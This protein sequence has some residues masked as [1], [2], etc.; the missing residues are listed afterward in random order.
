MIKANKGDLITVQVDQVKEQYRETGDY[1]KISIESNETTGGFEG[2]EQLSKAHIYRIEK[3]DLH[4]DLEKYGVRVG[5]FTLRAIKVESFSFVNEGEVRVNGEFDVPFKVSRRTKLADS[6]YFDEGVARAIATGLNMTEMEKLEE[7]ESS[8]EK[9]KNM[10][11]QILES[12][13]V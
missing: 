11:N 9:A 5:H 10:L 8:V 1:S 2:L 4:K 7:L 3:D 13:H 6:Y 12:A